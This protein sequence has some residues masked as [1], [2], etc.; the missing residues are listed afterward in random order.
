[1]QSLYVKSC[2]SMTIIKRFKK[3]RR[4]KER[5]K[6]K[7]KNQR[8]QPAMQQQEKNKRKVRQTPA[9]GTKTPFHQLRGV[10]AS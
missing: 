8:L 2:F 7:K 6:R 1:M 9:A 10:Y 5:K 4:K 3:K